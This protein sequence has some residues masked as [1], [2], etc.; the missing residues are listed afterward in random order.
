MS[1][2]RLDMSSFWHPTVY[3]KLYI[4][5][6]WLWV[7]TVFL[8]R[9]GHFNRNT[10]TH[11]NNQQCGSS[12]MCDTGP[13]L[14]LMF[15]LQNMEKWDIGCGMV[16]GSRWTGLNV[17]E[18]A[19]PLGF[20]LTKTWMSCSCLTWPYFTAVKIRKESVSHQN[21]TIGETSPGIC[22]KIMIIHTVMVCHI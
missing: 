19:N 15:T 9:T 17:W 6:Y 3:Q 4:F 22:H 8:E 18:T 5:F 16:V 1:L 21:W 10:C 7:Y 11:S 14:Q 13:G 12:M 20:F 2:I